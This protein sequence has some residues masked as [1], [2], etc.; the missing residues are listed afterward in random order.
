[1]AADRILTDD[2]KRIY[3]WDNIKFVMI[4]LVVAGHFADTLVAHSGV[5]KSFYL[6]I[7]AFHM[8]E[9]QHENPVCNPRIPF[10]NGESHFVNEFPVL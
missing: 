6:F 10:C 8:D 5:M 3:W 4:V 2:T 1:M 9:L 7:Y